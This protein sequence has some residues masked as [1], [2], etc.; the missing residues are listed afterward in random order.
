MRRRLKFVL[1]PWMVDPL[2][3]PLV[4][5]LITAHISWFL[6]VCLNSKLTAWVGRF[7][8]KLSSFQV[9]SSAPLQSTVIRKREGLIADMEKL[10]VMWLKEDTQRG[11][12]LSYRTLQAKAKSLFEEVKQRQ[13]EVA[14]DE[15]FHASRGWYSRFLTRLNWQPHT[16]QGKLINFK[17]NFTAECSK[18][19]TSLMH[20]DSFSI[21]RSKAESI[22][23]ELQ[24]GE[25]KEL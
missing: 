23:K 25:W 21:L 14:Q 17:M 9:D 4:R 18:S 1:F 13:G 6:S 19:T 7:V 20:F 16:E 12:D 3:N 5:Q 8:Y 22:F 15:T 11:E 24:S 10:L 2:L